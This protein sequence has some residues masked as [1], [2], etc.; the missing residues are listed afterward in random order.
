MSRGGEKHTS[1]DISHRLTDSAQ[2][3]FFRLPTGMNGNPS[4]IRRSTRRMLHRSSSA[5]SGLVRKGVAG[6]GSTFIDG[7]SGCHFMQPVQRLCDISY[8]HTL[9]AIQA[10][11]SALLS[12]GPFLL[13]ENQALRK[14]R[15]DTLL[16]IK[17]FREPLIM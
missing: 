5:T 14:R 2:N 3:T 7:S 12:S 15:T 16:T 17:M 9:C 13:N 6:S 1:R 8:I 11:S 10:T 4:P